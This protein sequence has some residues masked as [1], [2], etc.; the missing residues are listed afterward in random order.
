[1]H[2]DKLSKQ[3]KK[4]LL[5]RLKIINFFLKKKKFIKEF[6]YQKKI[7]KKELNFI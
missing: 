1:M 3:K 6:N 4:I 2:K 5:T 7:T